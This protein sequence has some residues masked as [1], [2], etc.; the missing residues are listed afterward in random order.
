MCNKITGGTDVKSASSSQQKAPCSIPTAKNIVIQCNV[1]SRCKLPLVG[2]VPWTI[3]VRRIRCTV[4]QKPSHL[5]LE[6]TLVF[7]VN[8]TLAFTISK[9]RYCKKSLVTVASCLCRRR[10]KMRVAPSQRDKRLNNPF[11]RDG[12]RREIKRFHRRVF[13]R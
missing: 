4:S 2:S 1:N 5:H 13:R 3:G 6:F 9:T 12:A 10:T 8:V 7:T 11:T